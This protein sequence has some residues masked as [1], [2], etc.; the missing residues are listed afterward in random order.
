MVFYVYFSFL[1]LAPPLIN[2][3]HPCFFASL[4]LGLPLNKSQVRIPRLRSN[5]FRNVS[6]FRLLSPR[7]SSMRKNFEFDFR[8]K[9]FHHLLVVKQGE[10]IQNAFILKTYLIVRVEIRHCIFPLFLILA[11]PKDVPKRKILVLIFKFILFEILN[12]LN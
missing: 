3:P 6:R 12:K 7:Q 5:T 10:T 11:I 1:K 4:S 9:T 8:F 2:W